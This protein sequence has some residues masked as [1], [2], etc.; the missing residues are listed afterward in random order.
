MYRGNPEIIE[1]QDTCAHAYQNS[2]LKLSCV[3]VNTTKANTDATY[4]K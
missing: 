2:M 4:H 1:H 3:V